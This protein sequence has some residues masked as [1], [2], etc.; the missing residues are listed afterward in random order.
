MDKPPVGGELWFNQAASVLAKLWQGDGGELTK[1]NFKDLALALL[2]I[3]TA[4]Q[5]SFNDIHNHLL[6]QQRLL[7]QPQT[8][9]PPRAPWILPNR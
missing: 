2:N 7:P 3:N 4:M 8:P 6:Q 1:E 5:M 9:I